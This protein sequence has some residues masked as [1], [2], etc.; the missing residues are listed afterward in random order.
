MSI[1]TDSVDNQVRLEP[2]SRAKGVRYVWPQHAS[3]GRECPYTVPTDTYTDPPKYISDRLLNISMRFDQLVKEEEPM[4][5]IGV[6]V[7]R[8][9]I[10][11]N[12]TYR[13]HISGKDSGPYKSYRAA[14]LGVINQLTLKK[15]TD[16][17][18]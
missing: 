15:Y 4:P 11:A 6:G 17:R 5:Y 12:E 10:G 18:G 1:T 13:W 2:Q 16:A 7:N 14:L 8:R 9:G 3:S